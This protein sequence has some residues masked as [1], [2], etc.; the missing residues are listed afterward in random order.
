MTMHANSCRSS[1]R[2]EALTSWLRTGPTKV[3]TG[4]GRASEL[5]P[6]NIVLKLPR[7]GGADK[8]ILIHR[9]VRPS[10]ALS[11]WAT[12]F[13][14]FA[15]LTRGYSRV[16]PLG[17]GG[18]LLAMIA[19]CIGMLA[20]GVAHA[21]E[22][23]P[24][25]AA[26][27]SGIVEKLP[28]V[29]PKTPAEE[30][31]SFRIQDGFRMELLAAEPLVTS[32]VA[33]TYDE[34]GRAYVCEMR[35]YPYTDKARHKP[36]Q[37]NPTDAPIGRVTLLEDTDGDGRFDKS[38][39]FA[40]GLS[41]PTGVACWKGGVFVCATPD[42]WYF[43]DTNGDG[44]ADI[45]R[46]VFT[47]FRKLNVQAVINNL[48]WGLDNE[49][50]GAGS[51]NGG[52]IRPGDQPDAKPIVMSRHDFRFDPVAER[53]E[54]LSGGARF[55][56]SFDDWG[57][58]F[59]CN[60]RN[61]VQH[62][63]LP[64]RYLARNPH[65]PVRSA[66]H[67]AAAFGDQLPVYRISAFEPWREVRARRWAGERD[68]INPRSE[69]IGGGVF[70]ST[71]G[72]TIYRGAAYPE[73]FHGA[74]VLGEVAN[75]VIH[76]ERLV[77]DGAT[78]KATPM[79]NKVEFVASTDIWFRPVNFVNAPDG[80]LH[81]VDMYRE[82][83]EHPWSIPDDI[84][85]AVDL[86]SGRDRGRLW[87][88]TPPNF[89]PSKPPRLGHAS[90]AELV[91]TLESPNSWWRETAQRL[92]FER[93]DKS[94]VPALH[95]L[96]KSG[97]TPQARL[98]A[99]WLLQGLVALSD[100]DVLT[101]LKDKTAGVR[102]NALRLAEGRPAL[103]PSVLALANDPDPRVRF[104]LAFTLGELSDPRALD[105]LAAIAKRDAAEPWIR[106]AVLSS[107]GDTSHHLL[108]RLLADKEFAANP[109]ARTL[110]RELAQVVGAR[111]RPDEMRAALKPINRPDDE[112]NLFMEVVL[113]L[114]EGLK[115]RGIGLRQA[116]I[117][118]IVGFFLDEGHKLALDADSVAERLVGTGALRYEDFDRAKP[119]LT[120][121]LKPT[122]PQEIQR[123]AVAALGSF[124][125]PETAP[126]LLA[127][128]RTQTPAIRA[129]VVLAMLG[130][131][132]R[133][134]PLL[135]AIE[136]GE[137]PANQIPF[138]RRAALLRSTDAKVKELATKLFSDSAPGARKEVVAKY[139][140]ALSLKG[141]A[142]R[143]K[144][145][146][147]TA[148]A[149][150][151][152]AGNLGKDIGPNLATV[153]QWNPEQLLLNILDPNR[154]VSPNFVSYTVETKDGRT[155]DGIIAEESA[156]SLTLKRGDGVTE[157]VLRRDI[158]S[159][160]GSGLSLMPEGVEAAITVEQMADLIAF[161]LS[162]NN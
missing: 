127:N 93:Q 136:R 21:A 72:L 155:L 129:E 79:F 80:T 68:T 115:P 61:P 126:M 82:N 65:L 31:A 95:Q 97:K 149:N 138:A 24:R 118:D 33:M 49:I 8:N 150:C 53:F 122:Q 69:L 28:S 67:D 133:I 10:G 105:A 71:S 146:F 60:I 111:N 55:G 104:Q 44:K 81:V 158:A 36:N 137:I 35:D 7:P 140:T 147:E 159:L 85:A 30:A 108:A 145:V 132:N 131:R 87:R 57:N 50:H 125:A 83:I 51:S 94:V 64:A 120:R 142:A 139:Q 152:V 45:R 162:G 89:K 160:T 88:L 156:A 62:V 58:R 84:H 54:L 123:A 77:S 74:A 11:G 148:C 151:H 20:T 106:T 19:S 99:L 59:L 46:K 92:L 91:A 107:T 144:K 101:G 66:I 90:T 63:V 48:V 32:P 41:W 3:A 86:E 154:E 76:A 56:G 47:G 98:H 18:A 14:G 52:Q 29:P 110:S 12:R 116:K 25:M 134:L 13:H 26:A 102:E 117:G 37:E 135:Q 109:L 100:N 27:A 70:T 42:I 103:L 141:D 43:K 5:N 16:A 17:R 38:T 34:N 112:K 23:D 73:K 75:N 143:G 96:V 15:A 157:T 4:E 119:T 153:R 39:V 78:F 40:D 161:L 1:R 2:Q 113:G 22:R 130:G 114:G 6:W 124:T 121:L 9:P 128:W